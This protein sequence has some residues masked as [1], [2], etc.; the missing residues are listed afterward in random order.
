MDYKNVSWKDKASGENRYGKTPSMQKV[1]LVWDGND[2][3][4]QQEFNHKAKTGQLKKK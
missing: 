1:T 3:I 4:P 2:W